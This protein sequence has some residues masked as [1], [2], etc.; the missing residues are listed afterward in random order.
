MQGS[1]GGLLQLFPMPDRIAAGSLTP[2]AVHEVHYTYR[3]WFV[4]NVHQGRTLLE[5][6]D[7]GDRHV[8]TRILHDTSYIA[9]YLRLRGT[10]IELTPID[11]RTTR[12]ELTAEFDRLLDPGWYFGPLQ[13]YAVSEMAE[14]LI[15]EVIVR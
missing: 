7:V 8:T 6:G 9:S 1:R 13:R 3:R 5:I 4:T 2:G 10:R 14:F 11:A 12:V 15:Q